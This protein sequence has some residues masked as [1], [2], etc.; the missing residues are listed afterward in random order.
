MSGM[1][2]VGSC[3]TCGE[4]CLVTSL[5]TTKGGLATPNAG[6]DARQVEE[7][8]VVTDLCD[9]RAFEKR[10]HVRAK[11]ERAINF[12]EGQDVM[13]DGNREAFERLRLD[14]RRLQDRVEE[15]ERATPTPYVTDGSPIAAVFPPPASADSSGDER[16]IC[17]T[18]WC[19]RPAIDA[20]GYCAEHPKENPEPSARA[21]WDAYRDEVIRE[22]KRLTRQAGDSRDWIA[23]RGHLAR[24]RG[25][26]LGMGA[27][28]YTFDG[29]PCEADDPENVGLAVQKGSPAE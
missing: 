1:V 24:W 10:P 11:I 18:Y 22:M 14:R 28:G 6:V 19:E 5:A 13:S 9:L 26:L 21:E 4:L 20:T 27:L 16:P 17:K 23:S 15:L 7:R 12:I 8:L 2:C 29:F 3:D 25:M